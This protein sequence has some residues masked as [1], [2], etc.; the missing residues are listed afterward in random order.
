MKLG[1]D[2]INA[3]LLSAIATG[4]RV[5]CMVCEVQKSIEQPLEYIEILIPQ[6][7]IDREAERD[8]VEQNS[9]PSIPQLLH[10]IVW[11]ITE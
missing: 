7:W 1:Y 9:A 11:P 10:T 8:A 3:I 4:L 2:G 5:C 6:L